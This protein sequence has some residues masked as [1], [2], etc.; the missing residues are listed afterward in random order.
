MA[1]QPASFPPDAAFQNRI[2]HLTGLYHEQA[3]RIAVLEENKCAMAFDLKE[4]QEALAASQGKVTWLQTQLDERSHML[5]VLRN[6]LIS[7]GV[8][9]EKVAVADDDDDDDDDDNDDAEASTV[10]PEEANEAE[11]E[12]PVARPSKSPRL[13]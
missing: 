11:A 8:V 5:A 6:Q 7:L 13:L 9:P 12:A 2:A 3:A 4:A 10:M 1:K